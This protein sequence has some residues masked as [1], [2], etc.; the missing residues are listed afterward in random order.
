M[1]NR[2]P[3]LSFFFYFFLLSLS[4]VSRDQILF[5][6]LQETDGFWFFPL[7]QRLQL[8]KMVYFLV[9]FFISFSFGKWVSKKGSFF[10]SKTEAK[11]ATA[12]I[13]LLRNKREVQVRQMRRDLSTLLQSGRDDTA[14]IRVSDLSCFWEEKINFWYFRVY[15]YDFKVLK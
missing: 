9:F 7:P 12:R 11:L 8:L 6:F 15:Y 1:Q 3:L 13:K 5:S 10:G 4:D 14:R 2:A